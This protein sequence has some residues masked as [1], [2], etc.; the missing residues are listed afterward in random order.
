MNTNIKEIKKNL[1]LSG[2]LSMVLGMLLDQP[3][4]TKPELLRAI[5]DFNPRIPHSASTVRMVIYRLRSLLLKHGFHIQSKYGQ[6]YYLPAADKA[7]IKALASGELAT[8]DLTS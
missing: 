1:N 4:V 7:L 8:G 3:I 5:E 6:G 2:Q